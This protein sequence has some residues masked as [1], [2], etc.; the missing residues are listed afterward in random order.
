MGIGR[1]GVKM[2]SIEEIGRVEVKGGRG[3]Y[4]GIW[5]AGVK[6]GSTGG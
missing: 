1:V 4:F 6:G 2:G 5:R 3:Y